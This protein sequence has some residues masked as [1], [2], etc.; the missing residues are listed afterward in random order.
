[1]TSG[2]RLSASVAWTVTG[3]AL[4]AVSQWAVVALTARL[5]GPQDLGYFTLATAVVTPILAFSQVQLRAVLATDARF[6]H[7]LRDFVNLRFVLTA[8][9][10]SV[11]GIAVAAVAE[12]RTAAAVIVVFVVAKGIDSVSD[13]LYGY[14]QRR[15]DM[16]II[17]LGQILN[18]LLS[19]AL[20]GVMLQSTG[21]IVL[22]MA[23]YAAASALTLFGWALP[24]S[25]RSRRRDTDDPRGQPAAHRRLL[26]TALPLGFV[27]LLAG[28]AANLPRYAVEISLGTTALGIFGAAAFLVLVGA[29]IITAL[30]QAASPRLAK[31]LA[32][33]RRADFG[34]T[35]A[36]LLALAFGLAA[37]GTLVAALWGTDVLGALYTPE[38]AERA[39]VLVAL[40]AAAMVAFPASIMAVAATSA[41]SFRAQLPVFFLVLA[42][43]VIASWL[44]VPTWGLM[45]AAAA[46]AAMAVVQMW[47]CAWIVRSTVWTNR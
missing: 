16:R 10:I 36:V 37:L 5:A 3:T 9:M 41:R 17:A 35:L 38:F 31:Q 34:R 4:F 23:G 19:V 40:A 22:A 15:E 33:G 2:P 1:M 25:I 28:L 6:E 24:A 18:G 12:D 26:W 45:G 47:G 39:D 21:S 32:E 20:F 44:L 29:N 30:G 14:H 7:R 11:T 27:M 13:I 42:V 46:T 8:A 43:G